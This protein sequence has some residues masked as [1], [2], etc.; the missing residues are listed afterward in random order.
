MNGKILLGGADHVR[1]VPNGNGAFFDAFDKTLLLRE[2]LN[3]LDYLQIIGVDNV[4]NKVLDP[5][6]FGFMKQGNL[7]AAMKTCSKRNAEEKVGVVAKLNGKYHVAEYSEISE[8][9]MR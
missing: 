8:E 3:S 7:E 2:K 9:M 6:F 1:L 4:L 5:L